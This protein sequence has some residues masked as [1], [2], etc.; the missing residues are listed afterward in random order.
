MRRLVPV[1]VL[2]LAA[3]AVGACSLRR[4]SEAADVLEDLSARSGPSTLKADTPAPRRE[5]VSFVVEGRRTAAD[6]YLP[7]EGA[8]ARMVLVP[9][10]ARKG[11]RDPRLVAFAETMARA[12]FEVLVPD[13]PSMRALQVTSA[14]ARVL[15]D[16][17]LFMSARS[18]PHP[19]GMTAISFAAGPAV[20]ALFQQD[21]V[22]FVVTIGAYY[23][24]TEAIAYFTTGY[25]RTRPGAPWRYRTPNAYG[26]WV[27]VS[28]NAARLD[29]ARDR[30]ALQEMARRKLD[31]LDADVA[32]LAAGLGPE[33]RAVYAL[34]TNH[35]PER[36]PTLI[37]RLPPGIR[38]E[39]EALDLARRNL[40]ALDVEFVLVHGRDDAIIPE[41][42]SMAL[43]AALD[44]DRV[45]LYLVDS[46]HHVDPEPPGLGD[47]LTLL[48]AVYRILELR[49]GIG[50]ARSA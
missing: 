29:D 19:L 10:A 39:I 41:T 32:D 13:L 34:L 35:D 48:Q 2:A 24:V 43:A 23:D 22:D 20:L 37:A 11:W 42:Q 4:V 28:S 21:A 30:A 1:L 6:L 8:L 12:R 27:F 5:P 14:D 44:P 40:H 50:L 47:M 46:L 36:V 31:D 38:A 25:Y 49:D 16:A 15:A 17:A 33:G 26:K 3:V 9:G 7:G 45:H 18:P